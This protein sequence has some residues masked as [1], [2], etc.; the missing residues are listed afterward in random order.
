MADV[1]SLSLSVDS[2]KV[3][4]ATVALKELAQAASASERQASK[5][6][7]ANDNASRTFDDFSKRVKRNIQDLQFQT[8][9]LKRSSAE[10]QRYDALRRAG[11]AASS[12][13][14]VAITNAVRALQAQKAAL[15]ETSL[16]TKAFGNA[17]SHVKGLLA[18][19]GLVFIIDKIIEMGRAAFEAAAGM[20]ELSEQVGLSAK[21]FQALLFSAT[22]NGLKTEQLETGLSKFSQKMG[23]A[24]EGS[25]EMI[26]A[27]TKLGVKNLDVA[28]KLRPTE[29]LLVDVAKA[30]TSI[31]DPARRSAAAVDFFGKAGTRM[32]PLLGQI[33]QG[34]D[35]WVEAARNAGAVISTE[36]IDALDKLDDRMARN[37]LQTRA[38]FAENIAT[39]EN[40]RNAFNKW[41]EDIIKSAEQMATSAGESITQFLDGISIEGARATASFLEAFRAMPEMIG[42]LFTNAWESAKVATNKGINDLTQLISDN[43]PSLLGGGRGGTNLNETPNS[44]GAVGAG[45]SERIKA[46]GDQ[47]AA[48]VQAQIDAAKQAQF[49]QSKTPSRATSTIGDLRSGSVGVS[50]SAVKASGDAA[51]KAAEKYDELIKSL[52]QTAEAQAKMTTAA[53]EGQVAFEQQKATLDAQEKLLGIYGLKLGYTAEQLQKVRDLLLGIAQGKAAEAF[54]VATTELRNQNVILE[55]QIELMN[56]APEIQAREI[57]LIKAKQE[58]EKGGLAITKEM[59][60]ARRAAIEQNELLKNQA[61]EL[62]KA[63]DLWMEPVK[64]ALQSIQ[65][66]AA[67]AFEG[68][69]TSG[70]LSFESLGE[71]FKKTITRMA[72][73]FLA[74]ATVRPVMSVLVNAISP[75]IG[76]QMGLGTGN[77]GSSSGGG[78]GG[79]F[80]GLGS[81]ISDFLGKTLIGGGE[82]FG[83]PMAGQSFAS[84]GTS[85]GLSVGGALSGLA[86]IGMGAYSMFSGGG[87][88]G[89]MLGGGLGMAGGLVSLLGPLTGLGAAAGPIGMGIGLLGALLPSLLGGGTPEPPTNRAISSLNFNNGQFTQSGGSYGMDAADLGGLGTSMKSLL[90]AAKV[91]ITSS[92]YGLQQQSFSQGDFSNATTFITGPNGQSMQWGQSS[93]PAQ[94]QKA[95]DTAAA[96]IAH[97]IMMQPGSG[98][99][100]ILRE[101]LGN[102]GQKNLQHAFSMDELNAAIQKLTVLDDAISGFGKTSTEAADAIKAVDDSFQVLF[103]TAKEFNISASEVDKITAERNKQRLNATKEFS[104]GIDQMLMEMKD[105]L[106][107]ALDANGKARE[108]DLVNND[109]F[110]RLV[111]GYESKRSQ[112]LEYY[113][114]QR[115]KIVKDA[116]E[117]QK[118]IMND[119][120]IV[121]LNSVSKIQD[122]IRELSPGGALSGLDPRAQLAGLRASADASMAQA[123]ANPANASLIDRAVADQR[124]FIDFNK[125][126][127]GGSTEYQ[128]D[129][130]NRIGILQ[131][132]QS[133]VVGTAM[134]QVADPIAHSYL[135]QILDAVRT[136]RTA[137]DNVMALLARYLA[138]PDQAAA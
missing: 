85:G 103:D 76:Q 60:D 90:D 136:D 67:D 109:E 122:L 133:G 18:G 26:E 77:V 3:D 47:A 45:L 19:L 137:V 126:F 43:L 58:A 54:S 49:S 39:L 63:N 116:G 55:K 91:K 61:E 123:V 32:L 94:Q 78:I 112:I 27:L 131:N 75:S 64:S 10:Q 71:I 80:G 99:S 121:T 5:L 115:Q 124:A 125:S 113:E 93:D 14:G 118:Q 25:K 130:Q 11:V 129:V 21:T 28:G 108:K 24:A 66:T 8:E 23:E 7:S 134:N 87:S 106:Q 30:I 117:A 74:L 44:A 69:L 89:S 9:Q 33:A 132:L 40:W 56:E 34:T 1:A 119:L 52:T 59:M 73:E 36:T 86:S 57:A 65:Q 83:P 114:L 41:A 46:V 15:G 62:K 12:A 88:T 84:L 127:T 95:L 38:L 72:A 29:D 70:K 42:T 16:A 79:M 111:D 101:G 31:D 138:N 20:G 135:A 50:T 128:R 104:D 81:G 53:G 102:F 110:L 6:K 35:T 4:Q 22:Q 97:S 96:N 2:S 13:E 37:S 98:V 120:L 48:T 92:P 82:N 51:G 17:W 107:A 105:P 68:I 100:D